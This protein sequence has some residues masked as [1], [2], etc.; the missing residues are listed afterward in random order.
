MKIMYGHKRLNVIIRLFSGVI[1]SLLILIPIA[2]FFLDADMVFK[3]ILKQEA[4]GGGGL[5]FLSEVFAQDNFPIVERFEIKEK[6]KKI[7]K[8]NDFNSNLTFYAS[9]IRFQK[10]T[11]I[12]LFK[13][14]QEKEKWSD[15]DKIPVDDI[16]RIIKDLLVERNVKQTV[17]QEFKLYEMEYILK[18]QTKKYVVGGDYLEVEIYRKTLGGAL[19]GRII[20]EGGAPLSK[21]SI[22][23]EGRDIVTN[24]FGGYAVILPPGT[25]QLTIKIGEKE[26]KI[27][28][29]TIFSPETTQN[30]MLDSSGK[31]KSI[32]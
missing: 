24:E 23:I 11:K 14:G 15:S 28:K 32:R 18:V 3:H 2:G 7:L 25:G 22:N 21:T 10:P 19:S 26:Y 8:S 31:L 5:G 29:I 12:L 4:K 20:K 6:H 27:E 17:K 9:E 16:K 30:W 1:K 13:T